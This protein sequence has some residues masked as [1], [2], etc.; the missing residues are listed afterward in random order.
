MNN[1]FGLMVKVLPNYCGPS[2]APLIR[3]FL[4]DAGVDLYSAEDLYLEPGQRA[5]IG[6]G[7]AVALPEEAGIELQVRPRSGLAAK[8]GITVVN[9]PG[10][11]DSGYRGEIKVILQNTNPPVTKRMFDALLD[12]VDDATSRIGNEFSFLT[13]PP[14][15][16]GNVIDEDYHD[17]TLHIHR[18]D[19]IAQL[20]AAKHLV[21][22]PML[23]NTL[24]ESDRGTG[25]LGSTG[26]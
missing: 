21:I 24:P 9:S 4:G 6:T 26:V 15:F 11:I 17:R 10:T 7:L 16:R 2:N 19:R 20:V 8:S 18:G 14:R 1:E 25:G 3:A 5:V 23:V 22:I 12:Y 13:S